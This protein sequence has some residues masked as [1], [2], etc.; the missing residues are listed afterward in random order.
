MD[1][2][3]SYAGTRYLNLNDDSRITVQLND[4]TC[5]FDDDHFNQKGVAI[6]NQFFLKCILSD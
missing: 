1:I 5:F 6:L 3:A 4:T 2:A